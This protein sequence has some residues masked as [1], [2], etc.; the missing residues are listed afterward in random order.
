MQNSKTSIFPLPSVDQ[1]KGITKI[2]YAT[3]EFVA[4]HLKAH[5][6]Y[7]DPDQV[8]NLVELAAWIL[9]HAIP[10][11]LEELYPPAHDPIFKEVDN[12]D[13]IDPS[14]QVNEVDQ[15]N[16]PFHNPLFTEE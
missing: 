11:V 8:A 13:E 9:D 16:F 6:K 15:M 14:R 7:P 2:E 5:G 4:A 1:E 3:I 10:R 12:V